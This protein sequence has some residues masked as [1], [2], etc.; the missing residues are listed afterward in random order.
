MRR[1]LRIVLSAVVSAGLLYWL[2]RDQWRGLLPVIR[3]VDFAQL[4][5]A[6]IA[7]S[8][9]HLLRTRRI[10]L[11]ATAQRHHDFGAMFRSTTYFLFISTV[12]P[13]RLGEVSLPLLL[14][15]Q[16]GVPL[17]D[18]VGVL[19]LARLYDLLMVLLLGAGL[20]LHASSQARFERAALPAVT[21]GL[22]AALTILCLPR[23]MAWLAARTTRWRRLPA[24]AARLAQ[25]IAAPAARLQ[26]AAML[27]RFI[28]QTLLQWL[29]LL[30]FY[31]LCARACGVDSA[32]AA[33]LAGLA[34]TL[35]AIQPV[36]GIAGLGVVEAAW[37]FTLGAFGI[38]WPVALASALVMHVWNILCT[39]ATAALVFAWPAPAVA[40][41]APPRP[42]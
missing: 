6:A 5:A 17:A 23:S 29:L 19:L 20:L 3:A 40:S 4:A 12:L 24:R 9:S 42:E 41:G 38:A 28:G 1:L 37:A 26:G 2:L 18:G 32:V 25:G 36:N 30:A 35:A 27:L 8:G 7:W 34:S 14:R 16:H 11:L 10:A 39:G 15:R 13:L 33:M 21:F 22:I 31:V